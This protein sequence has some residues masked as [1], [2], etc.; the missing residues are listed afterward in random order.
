MRGRM[1]E[2]FEMWR[3]FPVKKL[4]LK[5]VSFLTSYIQDSVVSLT[6]FFLDTQQLASTV[7]FVTLFPPTNLSS[8][9]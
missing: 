2:T 5:M 3:Y 8:Y 1:M 4:R 9:T 7:R 6:F